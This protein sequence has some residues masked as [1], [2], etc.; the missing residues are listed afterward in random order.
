MRSLDLSVNDL[1]LNIPECQIAE[2]EPFVPVEFPSV[3]Y[4]VQGVAIIKGVQ[5]EPRYIWHITAL[6]LEEEMNVLRG[7]FTLSNQRRR[8]FGYPGISLIDKIHRLVESQPR[9]R[10]IAPGTTEQTM[11]GGLISYFA[12]FEVFMTNLKTPKNGRFY[13]CSFDLAEVEKIVS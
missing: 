7:M 1:I 10:A 5:H 6:L 9:T 4:S 2:I 3:A 11:P 12:V 8:V 13:A